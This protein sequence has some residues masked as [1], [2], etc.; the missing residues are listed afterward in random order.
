[1]R[2]QPALGLLTC[3]LVGCGV[4]SQS[5]F[6]RDTPAPEAVALGAI[7]KGAPP[8]L[9]DRKL[10]YQASVSLV[11]SDLSKF[12]DD[13]ATAIGKSGGLIADFREQRSTGQIRQ[14]T[15]TVRVPSDKFMLFVGDLGGLG[16]AESRQMTADDVTEQYIDL[17]ARLKNQHQLEARLLEMVAKNTGEVKDLLT[18]ES[19]LSRIRQEIERMEG[20]LRVMT[21]R[22]ALS[23]ITI[24]AREQHDYQPP[25]APTFA[26]KIHTAWS[27]SLALLRQLGENIA[28]AIVWSAPWLA[29]VGSLLLP[30]WLLA[31]NQLKRRAGN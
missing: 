11:V 15:W 13:L 17:E 9:L 10:V 3:L 1:M 12:E 2:W 26:G 25:E 23:T 31:R 19:E 16:L 14:G 8:V 22:I 30:L 5:E 29:V 7:T 28:L 4:Q 6:K 18:M 21:D 27:E 20:Q 24:H